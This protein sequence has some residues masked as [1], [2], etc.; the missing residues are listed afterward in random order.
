MNHQNPIGTMCIL[1]CVKPPQCVSPHSH[2]KCKI[3]CYSYYLRKLA[4]WFLSRIRWHL[5]WFLANAMMIVQKH[6]DFLPLQNNQTLRK[7]ILFIHKTVEVKIAFVDKLNAFWDYESFEINCCRRF[8]FDCRCKHWGVTDLNSILRFYKR[9]ITDNTLL[10]YV[11]EAI[12]Y[13]NPNNK[14]FWNILG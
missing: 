14:Y 1:Q 2:A 7:I 8:V 11:Y 5:A 9:R 4:E 12:V 6:R 13:Q 10:L 3:S